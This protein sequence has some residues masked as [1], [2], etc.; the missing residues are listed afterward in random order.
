[1][2]SRSLPLRVVPVWVPPGTWLSSWEEAAGGPPGWDLSLL[3]TVPSPRGGPLWLQKLSSLPVR[4]VSPGTLPWYR[5]LG[6]QRGERGTQW[7][8]WYFLYQADHRVSFQ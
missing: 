6:P 1:M 3:G 2:G 5:F 7:V 8:R 4:L